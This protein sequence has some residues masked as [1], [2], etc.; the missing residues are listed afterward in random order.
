MHS[1]VWPIYEV[2]IY[3]YCNVQ[4]KPLECIGAGWMYRYLAVMWLMLWWTRNAWLC[5]TLAALYGSTVCSTLL[6]RS[7]C[8]LLCYCNY[9]CHFGP[10]LA[11]CTVMQYDQLSM[12]LC[13]VAK[14]YTLQLKCPNKWIGAARHKN[15]S[16]QL[17]TP[18]VDPVPSNSPPLEPQFL[19][20]S[21][22]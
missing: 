10:F 15:I 13:T 12:M 20:L 9:Y 19:V 18:Y 3:F 7:V 6:P 22:K 4:Q 5:C 1:F 8:C 16:L 17:S 14:Q 11:D 21:G 2:K